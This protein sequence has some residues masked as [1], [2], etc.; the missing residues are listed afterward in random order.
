MRRVEQAVFRQ[1]EDAGTHR[2]VELARTALLE[3][4]A[5]GAADQHAITGEGHRLIVE[6]IGDAAIGVA[7][8]GP[9]L[10]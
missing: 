10:E 8:R 3:V 9:H 5:A 4:G 6:H 2:A 1:R 7:G